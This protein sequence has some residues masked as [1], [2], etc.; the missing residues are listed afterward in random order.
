MPQVEGAFLP[1]TAPIV[2][3]DLLERAMTP[4]D[5]MALG[6]IDGLKKMRSMLLKPGLAEVFACGYHE[7]GFAAKGVKARL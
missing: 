6:C 1:Q 4:S 5:R 2:L 7:L 3:I